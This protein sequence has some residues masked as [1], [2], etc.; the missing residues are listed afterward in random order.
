MKNAVVTGATG[1]LGFALLKEL[2]QNGVFVYAL[3]RR[4]SQRLSRLIGLRNV[5]I[6][7]LDLNYADFTERLEECDVFYHL[8][9]E[10]GRNDFES[11]YA[12]VIRAVNSLKIA[13][14][15]GCKRFICT[16]SQAEYG[17]TD[18]A[19]TEDTRL[20]PATAYGACKAAAYYLTADLAGRL[21]IEHTWARVFS[22][23]GPNDAP[24]TLVMKLISDLANAGES[25]TDT[26]G[27]HIWNYLYESDAAKALRLLGETQ[28]T[29]TV[30]NIASRESKPL[31]AYIEA[32]RANVNPTSVVIYGNEKSAV[33]LDVFPEKLLCSIGEYE[34]T[35]FTRGIMSICV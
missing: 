26:D 31:R 19:I 7:E 22:V 14:A 25:T 15:S 18:G 27:S 35:D 8:A 3:C 9:W 16:G 24:H 10:G 30:F 6:Y 20:K 28:I 21:G 32:L 11:Q 12:N 29:N 33:N 1:F 2:T 4:G 23:Y 17:Y 13:S 34:A 5:K